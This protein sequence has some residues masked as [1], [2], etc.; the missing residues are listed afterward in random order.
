MGWTIDNA[1]RT[2]EEAIEDQD[3]KKVKAV[4]EKLNSGEIIFSE[5]SY[6]DVLIK[7]EEMSTTLTKEQAMEIL[8]NVEHKHDASLGI[9]WDVIQAHIENYV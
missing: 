2:L 1:L 4:R 7:A 6:K 5:W 9:N 3:W 8:S